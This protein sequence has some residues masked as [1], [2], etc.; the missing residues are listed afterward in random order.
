MKKIVVIDDEPDVRNLIS[1]ILSGQYETKEIETVDEVIKFCSENEV[2]LIITDLFMPEKSG[3]DLIETIKSL[4]PD[5]KFLA[6]SGGSKKSNCDFLPVAEIV[7]ANGTLQKPF[8]PEELRE[9]V[10][11]LMS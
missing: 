10:A 7:G 5:I 9:K 1:I 4:N 3:L 6:I 11:E 2:D 8:T